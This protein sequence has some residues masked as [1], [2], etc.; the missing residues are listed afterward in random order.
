MFFCPL[1]AS[2]FF[3]FP[4]TRI[5]ARQMQAA[6][7]MTIPPVNT[8]TI[9]DTQLINTLVVFV[10]M[11]LMSKPGGIAAPLLDLPLP[12]I[13]NLIPQL[14][15]LVKASAIPPVL[16]KAVSCTLFCSA[17]D[18]LC[19]PAFCMLFTNGESSACKRLWKKNR[20]KTPSWRNRRKK[21]IENCNNKLNT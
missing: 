19:L 4:P 10:L 12:Q 8:T 15:P 7:I 9:M 17:W 20:G 3:L 16:Q 21:G 1:P 2:L 11:R 6:V 13:P 14:L 18:P 5:L